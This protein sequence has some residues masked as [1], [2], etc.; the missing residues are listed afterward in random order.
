MA[1]T[2]EKNRANLL[3]FYEEGW[4]K[5]D[6]SV[7]EEIVSPSFVDHQSVPGLPDGRDG[8]KMLPVIFRGAFPDLQVTVE[9]VIAE[10]TKVACRW[11]ATGTHEGELFGI[12]RTGRSVDVSATAIYKVGPD[13]R[14]TEGW[15]DRDDLGLMQQLVVIPTPGG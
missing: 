3:R 6:Q 2:A 7:F 15:L 10:P 4:N 12:P 13:G 8:F 1:V 9:D 14:W 5:G 11:R